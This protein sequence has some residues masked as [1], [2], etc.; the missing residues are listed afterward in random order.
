MDHGAEEQGLPTLEEPLQHALAV[1]RTVSDDQ[2]LAVGV[3]GS[4]ATNFYPQ[5]LLVYLRE[6][7]RPNAVICRC[8]FVS[9]RLHGQL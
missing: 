2:Q 9:N 1:V 4:K 8:R 5:V 7:T 3:G 6:G